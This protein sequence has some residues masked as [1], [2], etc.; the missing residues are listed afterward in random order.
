MKSMF[1]ALLLPLPVAAGPLSDL[2]MAPRL[3]EGVGEGPLLTYAE[4]RAAPDSMGGAAVSSGRLLVA[5]VPNGRGEQF[6]LS[7]DV[8]GRVEPLLEFP[9]NGPNPVLLY[10]L[11]STARSMAGATGG[12]AFHIR[13]RMRE[14]VAAADLG[15]GTT[16]R[17][18]VMRPFANDQNRARMGAFAELSVRLRYDPD[19]PDRILELSADTQAAG[20]GYYERLTLEV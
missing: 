18:V 8:D 19:R 3:L 7:R 20:H 11:E 16:P 10:F 2:L 4:Q 9:V 5:V 14:A 12:S 1:L 6:L 15:T 13:T 17:E